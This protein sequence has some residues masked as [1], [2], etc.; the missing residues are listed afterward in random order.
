MRKAALDSFLKYLSA[1]RN[2]SPNTKRAYKQDI[3]QFLTYLARGN[4]NLQQLTHKDLRRYLAY[5]QLRYSRKS[6]TRKLA[7]IRT[8]LKYLMREGDIETNPAIF[9]SSP[10]LDR[11]LPRVL[12]TEAVSKLLAAPCSNSPFDIRD[13]ALLEVLYGTGIR[14]SEL[15]GLN[16]ESIDANRREIRVLG[17][18]NKERIIP[19]NINALEAIAKYLSSPRDKLL[20]QGRLKQA[21]KDKEA[22]FL[23]KNGTRLSKV[24]VR[25]IL[26]KCARKAGIEGAISPHAIRHSFATHLL[27]A[28]ADLRVVQELLGHADL[29][30]TQIY[31]HLSRGKLKEIYSKAHPRA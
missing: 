20:N 10:K 14:V 27:E 9:I 3:K 13:K 31:T 7:S 6:V 30:S 8:F 28:G 24:G 19:V 4:K 16:I 26:S 1:E 2:V 22:L 21:L 23:N 17:K 15:V 5:L 29:S 12:K 11:K 25:A 18:G